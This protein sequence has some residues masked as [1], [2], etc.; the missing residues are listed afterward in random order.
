MTLCRTMVSVSV[1]AS[2]LLASQV[3]QFPSETK[4][5]MLSYDKSKRSRQHGVLSCWLWRANQSGGPKSGNQRVG[6]TVDDDTTIRWRMW[7][8]F[9]SGATSLRRAFITFA[10]NTQRHNVSVGATYHLQPCPA[11]AGTAAPPP[12]CPSRPPALPACPSA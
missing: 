4:C 5:S 3:C 10:T 8:D 7:A 1:L 12:L 9:S 2:R 6:T 11:S